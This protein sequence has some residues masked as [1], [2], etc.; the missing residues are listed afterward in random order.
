MSRTLVAGGAGFIGSHLCDSLVDDGHDVVCLDNLTSGQRRNV[1]D[2]DDRTGGEFRLVD[3]DVTA[4]LHTVLRDAG[5]DPMALDRVYHL[6]SRASP[7]DFR[8]HALDIALTNSIGTHNVLQLAAAAD[9]RVLYA[10]TSEIYGDPEVHPQ[11]ESYNGNVDPRG[12]RA[13]YDESKRFGETLATVYERQ[14]DLDVRTARLFNTYG[15]RMR[16]DDGRVIP[17]FLTQA[18]DGRDLTVYGDG[19]QT[20]SFL[21]VTDLVDGLRR[22]MERPGLGGEVVN[23]GSTEEMTI[24]ELAERTLE[25]VETDS[26]TVYKPLPEGDPERR[27]PDIDRACRELDWSPSTGLERGLTETREYFR[28]LTQPAGE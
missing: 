7:E 21:Y 18:L 22:L 28:T 24:C 19:S 10:S 12:P 15:P 17:T 2:L 6:A 5:V 26:Q 8:T 16:P 1:A 25:L 3:G 4:D 20:R 9:A 23:L 13:C 14:I 27:Q 11:P